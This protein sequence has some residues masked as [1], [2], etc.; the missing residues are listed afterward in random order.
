[1]H[2]NIDE[3]AADTFRFSAFIPDVGPTGMTFNQFLIR[4]DE[5]LLFHTPAT[6]NFSRWS[7]RRSPRSC[8]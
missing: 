2:T 5:P 6:A 3:I 8:R 4:D 7:P 1:M